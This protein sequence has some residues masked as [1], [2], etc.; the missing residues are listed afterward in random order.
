M[1]TRSHADR[2]PGR[3]VPVPPPP[4]DPLR[5][6]L[7]DGRAR[8]VR[9]DLTARPPLPTR[10]DRHVSGRPSRATRRST[11]APTMTPPHT[12][13]PSGGGA[14][15]TSRPS[16]QCPQE[17]SH[18]GLESRGSAAE[19]RCQGG[20]GCCPLDES[21]RDRLVIVVPPAG[22]HEGQHVRDDGRASVV[23]Q[24]RRSMARWPRTRSSSAGSRRI[25]CDDPGRRPRRTP[26]RLSPAPHASRPP[27]LAPCT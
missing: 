9:V 10:P 23:G 8:S 27:R 18:F 4:Q 24:V 6:A 5:L 20:R 1:P 17:R 19:A 21:R 26:C 7:P 16:D 2:Q 12:P 14:T 22:D 15:G 13:P 11:P 25:T 3:A